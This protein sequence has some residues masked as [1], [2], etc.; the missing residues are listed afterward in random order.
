MPDKSIYVISGMA[1]PGAEVLVK[2]PNSP[3]FVSNMDVTGIFHAFITLPQA[4]DYNICGQ[5]SRFKDS[6][7]SFSTAYRGRRTPTCVSSVS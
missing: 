1:D 3:D 6:L 5:L 7:E 4:G 2:V